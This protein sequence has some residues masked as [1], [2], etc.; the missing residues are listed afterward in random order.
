MHLI[1]PASSHHFLLKH[2]V[3]SGDSDL[4]LLAPSPATGPSIFMATRLLGCDHNT[5]PAMLL[6][7]TLQT[8]RAGENPVVGYGE[9]AGGC[10][11]GLHHGHASLGPGAG[12]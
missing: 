11:T 8:P 6:C 4:C 3:P 10:L 1:I 7:H 2:L 12:E 5:L 9:C